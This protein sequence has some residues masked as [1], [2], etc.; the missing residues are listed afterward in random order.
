MIDIEYLRAQAKNPTGIYADVL[1][2]TYYF[3][4]QKCKAGNQDWCN[5]KEV[6]YLLLI[7]IF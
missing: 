6:S 2:R 3:T 4:T 5:S 7:Y 1:I